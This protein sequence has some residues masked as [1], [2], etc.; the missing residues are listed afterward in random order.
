[1]HYGLAFANTGPA[2][3]P[4]YATRFARAAE[5]AGFESLW[6][7]EHVIWPSSYDSVY[8]YHPSGRMAGHESVPIPDPLVWLTW[9]GAATSTIRLATGILLLP[10][11]QPLVLAK[12][13]AT[14]D[15]LTGGRLDLGIGIGWL[16]EE[17]EAL[18]IPFS[19]R[20]ARTDEYIDVLRTL[21]SGDAVSFDGDLVSFSSVSS[22]PKPA[23]GTIP[24][25]VGG[26]S[27]GAARRAG[28]LGD[29]FWPGKGS[30]DELAEIFAHAR[31]AAEMAGR[32]P[33]DLVLCATPPH[34]LNRFEEEVEALSQM[35]VSRIILPAYY[36][37]APEPEEGLQRVMDRVR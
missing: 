33:E 23:G 25:Y 2:T 5:A 20:A 26:H 15:Q 6:T 29:G 22:N 12:A 11:R 31:Q 19:G 18:G 36:L 7:V 8:P 35:G 37:F 14:L 34:I 21:W 3:D 28:R 27:S 10:E 30:I 32:D 4:E 9:V 16:R 17:F 13:A 24:I 1:M